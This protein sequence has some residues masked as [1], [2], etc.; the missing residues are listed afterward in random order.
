MRISTFLVSTALIGGLFVAVSTDAGA[1]ALPAPGTS[2]LTP[3]GPFLLT[4]NETGQA[5]ISVNGG[6]TTTLTGTLMTNPSNGVGAGPTL[7]YV[8]PE[9]VVTGSV[10]FAEPGGGVSD[11]IRFTDANGTISGGPGTLMIFYS[12]IEAGDTALA[13]TGF[14]ANINTGN[15]LNC[16]LVSTPQCFGFETAEG[17]P[18]GFDYRPG[19]VPA[20][21]NNQYVGISDPAT[22][23]EPASLALLGSALAAMG[24]IR[25]RRSI[26]TRS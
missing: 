22:V 1:Q 8:L 21:G 16:G 12:D 25:R 9:P 23:P 6:P 7:T 5:T 2:A 3:T 17:L 4:F 10:S 20:F 19:G 24:L 14:P 13:D 11:W 15:V 26:K 18:N